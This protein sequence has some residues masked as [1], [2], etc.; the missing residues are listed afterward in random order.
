MKPTR[1]FMVSFIRTMVSVKFVIIRVTI[2][3]YCT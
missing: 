3:M 2:R 1:L